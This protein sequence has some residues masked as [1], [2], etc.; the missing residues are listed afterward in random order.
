M[1]RKFAIVAVVA[2]LVSVSLNADARDTE[3][4]PSPRHNPSVSSYCVPAGSGAWVCFDCK[5]TKAGTLCMPK[6]VVGPKPFDPTAP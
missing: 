2:G 3:Q 1:K 5:E 6:L 4:A